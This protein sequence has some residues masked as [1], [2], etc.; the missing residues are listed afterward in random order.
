MSRNPGV[1]TSTLGYHQGPVTVP[2]RTTPP[3]ELKF[4]GYQKFVVVVLA[5]LQFTTGASRRPAPQ[6]PTRQPRNAYHNTPALAATH[7]KGSLGT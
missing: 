4:S 6:W 5:F 2:R 3:L 7:R 1:V